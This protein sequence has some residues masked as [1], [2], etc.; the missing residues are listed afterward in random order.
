MHTCRRYN[1]KRRWKN[2]RIWILYQKWNALYQTDR[3]KLYRWAQK[4]VAWEITINK[5]S[6]FIHVFE[7]ISRCFHHSLI[8]YKWAALLNQ[9]C[10]SMPSGFGFVQ[11]IS[12][13]RSFFYFCFCVYFHLYHLCF[14]RLSG[15]RF[16]LLFSSL[17]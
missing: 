16:F 3:D 5:Y 2:E 11:V 1:T 15:C 13:Q 7:F 4:L 10:H 14:G 17:V 12:C 8:R 9:M 6:I